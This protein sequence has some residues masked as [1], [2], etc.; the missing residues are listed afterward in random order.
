VLGPDTAA[1]LIA[2]EQQPPAAAVSDADRRF[3]AVVNFDRARV[4]L[5]ARGL[6]SRLSDQP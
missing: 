5:A 4:T 2:R 6:L 1:A 3:D